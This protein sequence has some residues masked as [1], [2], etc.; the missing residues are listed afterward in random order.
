MR[1]LGIDPPP[2]QVPG[3]P[4]DGSVAAS[5]PDTLGDELAPNGWVAGGPGARLL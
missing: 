1:N 2:Q 5:L 4:G 3:Q